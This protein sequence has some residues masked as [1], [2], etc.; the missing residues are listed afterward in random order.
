ML[1]KYISRS[2]FLD[3]ILELLYFTESD[4]EVLRPI[5]FRLDDIPTGTNNYIFAI[6]EAMKELELSSVW[7][8]VWKFCDFSIFFFKKWLSFM[9]GRSHFLITAVCRREVIRMELSPKQKQQV[10][11]KFDSYCKKTIKGEVKHYWRELTR[12]KSKESLFSELTRQELEQ[13][14]SMDDYCFDRRYFPVMGKAVEVHDRQIAEAFQ[15]LSEKKREILLMLYFLDMTET[16]IASY[17]HLVQSTI[18]YH[19][20]VSLNRMRQILEE[21]DEE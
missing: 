13:L 8:K 15:K 12:Q 14:Y 20:K 2:P 4:D 16:E 9:K 5:S 6:L 7:K 10:Q 17:L 3:R 1:L 19:K 18:H 11:M 21:M